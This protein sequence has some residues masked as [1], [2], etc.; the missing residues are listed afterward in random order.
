MLW[1]VRNENIGRE[2]ALLTPN[3]HGDLIVQNGVVD[4]KLELRVELRVRIWTDVGRQNASEDSCRYK[5]L[6][7]LGG[8][9]DW[10]PL[11]LGYH[12]V[13][14]VALIDFGWIQNLSDS[15]GSLDAF[16]PSS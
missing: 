12:H 15:L 11:G 13:E 5:G 3:A 4:W 9:D 6:Y 8:I 7:F 14:L 2:T 1:D 10:Q 16:D